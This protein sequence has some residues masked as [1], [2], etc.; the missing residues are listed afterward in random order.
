MRGDIANPADVAARYHRVAAVMTARVA[1]V[2][3]AGWER[4]SPC[5]GWTARDVL[6]HV[7]EVHSWPLEATGLGA[8]G[9]PPATEHPVAAW[10]AASSTL[11]RLLE[12][13]DLAAV[14]IDV[15][16]AG[17]MPAAAAVDLIVCGD[18]VVHTWDLSWA[19]GQDARIDPA[20]LARTKA[21]VESLGEDTIRNPGLYADALT[22]PVGADAQTEFL[23]YLGRKAW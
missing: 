11:S 23:A 6:A 14:E 12:D 18:L 10:D 13:A 20:E 1:G 22:P 8:D 3:D 19:T 17:R 21:A 5:A 7:V 16:V 9:I 15:A 4:P 2:D